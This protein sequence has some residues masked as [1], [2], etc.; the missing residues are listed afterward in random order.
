M[1]V[2]RATCCR[3]TSGPSGNPTDGTKAV[4]GMAAVLGGYILQA[5]LETKIFLK[6]N[7][8]DTADNLR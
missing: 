7:H 2:G 4:E 8:T 5:G 3:C 1:A 6:Q